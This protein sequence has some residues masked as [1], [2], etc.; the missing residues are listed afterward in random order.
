MNISPLPALLKKSSAAVLAGL[1]SL[2]PLQAS[3]FDDDSHLMTAVNSDIR[4][5]KDTARDINRKPASIMAFSGVKKGQVIV[6]M[7]AGSGYYSE[8]FSLAVGPQG[9][10][11]AHKSR[12][13][14]E[15][16]ASFPNIKITGDI[17]L[18]DI[19]AEADLVFTALNYH[20]IVNNSKY[21]RQAMFAGIKARLKAGGLFVVIDH[22]SGK[23]TGKSV[24][25]TLHRIDRDFVA[26]EIIAAGFMLDGESHGLEN[27]KDDHSKK[28]FHPSI[29]GMIDRFVLR[30]KKAQ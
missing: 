20:D 30:F 10:V 27:D 8:L 14:K 24:S 17:N 29:R 18:A 9:T 22:D 21:D 11:Y 19:P 23:D 2:T 12:M 13:T 6:D 7:M 16:H 26:T 3:P 4:L 1:I 15:R 25:N 28:P 5:A